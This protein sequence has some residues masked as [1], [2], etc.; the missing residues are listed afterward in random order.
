[1]RLISAQPAV[2][3]V[4]VAC[5]SSSLSHRTPCFPRTRPSSWLVGVAANGADAVVGAQRAG[6][7]APGALELLDNL[8]VIGFAAAHAAGGEGNA[9][10]GGVGAGAGGSGAEGSAVGGGSRA[11]GSDRSLAGAA[12]VAAL[13]G[14]LIGRADRGARIG[15]D[16]AR[17]RGAVAGAVG[18]TD[19]RAAVAHAGRLLGAELDGAAD[20]AHLHAGREPD[21]ARSLGHHEKVFSA[22]TAVAVHEDNALATLEVDHGRRGLGAVGEVVPKFAGGELG[23][24]LVGPVS[25]L[26]RGVSCGVG[27][28]EIWGG[29]RTISAESS[30]LAVL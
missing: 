16:P 1:M 14:A 6:V 10:G 5:H 15:R 29:D 19:D 18:R 12:G 2:G 22:A 24:R 27:S 8:P 4:S 17:G 3:P 21:V 13:V 30:M 11:V 28:A 20:H 7:E 25:S 9:L 23:V 26:S